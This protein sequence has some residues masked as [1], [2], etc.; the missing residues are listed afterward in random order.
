LNCY[1]N[2]EFEKSIKKVNEHMGELDNI[3]IKLEE[4]EDI[5]GLSELLKNQV[6]KL[7]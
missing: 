6:K 5:K 3:E 1:S 4:N 7:E 2:Q